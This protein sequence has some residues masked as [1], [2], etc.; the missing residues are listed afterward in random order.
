MTPSGMWSIG[1][2]VSLW[3]LGTVFAI[4]KKRLDT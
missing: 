4:H 1:D 3:P 2:L